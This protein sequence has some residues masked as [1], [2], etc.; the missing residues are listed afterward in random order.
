ME[1][2]ANVT[3]EGKFTLAEFPDCPGCQTFADPG[4]DITVLAQNALAGWLEA[5]LADDEAPARPKTHRGR[6]GQLMAIDV[7]S[8]LAVRLELRWAREDEHLTQA[9]LARRLHIS[10]QQ[11][12]KLEGPHGNPTIETLEKVARGLGRRLDIQLAPV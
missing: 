5:H 6:V 9:Q 4:E 1:Y 3:K 8:S 10:Q 2:I 12:A 7:P 11:V